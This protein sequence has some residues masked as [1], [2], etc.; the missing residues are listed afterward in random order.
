MKLVSLFVVAIL[1]MSVTQAEAKKRRHSEDANGNQATTGIVKSKKTG[2]TARVSFSL[3]SK[4]QAYIDELEDQHGAIIYSMGGIRRGSCSSRHMHPCGKA[5]DICQLRRGIVAG[6][7][8]LPDRSAI[9]KIANRHGLFEGGQWC[10]HDYGH[11]QAGVTAGPC[12]SNSMAAKRKR[13]RYA[14]SYSN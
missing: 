7:C 1:A 2:A 13:N 12:N 6:K 10:H 11:V 9:A 8:R 5:L 14:A 3:A 4:F